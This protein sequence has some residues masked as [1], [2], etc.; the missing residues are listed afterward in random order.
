MVVKLTVD[1]KLLNN[2]I[3]AVLESDMDEN[4]KSG[5]HSLL[6]EI[7]DEVNGYGSVNIKKSPSKGIGGKAREFII[8]K[9]V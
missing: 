1:L 4:I 5:L 2:Q 7:Y 3:N 8:N 6:G 9:V